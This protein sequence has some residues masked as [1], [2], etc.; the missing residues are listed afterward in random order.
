MSWQSVSIFITNSSPLMMI[1]I[2]LHHNRLFELSCLLQSV[3]FTLL[4]CSSP[5]SLI[6][7]SVLSPLI[8]VGVFDLYSLTQWTYKIPISCNAERLLEFRRLNS[9]S[10]VISTSSCEIDPHHFIKSSNFNRCGRTFA[11]LSSLW[12]S[13][14]FEHPLMFRG[15]TSKGSKCYFFK[16]VVDILSLVMEAALLAG[17]YLHK[18]RISV[19]VQW[20]YQLRSLHLTSWSALSSLT[21]FLPAVCLFSWGP[22]KETF[23][24][25]T[26]SFWASR[27]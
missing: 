14:S 7:A 11:T 5:F 10:Y 26:N 1:H 18:P 23:E 6:S 3:L 2:T 19:L 16:D 12:I 13:L 15:R 4:L 9:W 8:S 22:P 24:S 17:R 27:Q 21:I 25:L 20:I